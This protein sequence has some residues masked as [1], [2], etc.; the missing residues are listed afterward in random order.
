MLGIDCG[1]GPRR[2]CGLADVGSPLTEDSRRTDVEYGL[3]HPRRLAIG[4]ACSLA[5]YSFVVRRIG[6]DNLMAGGVLVWL[7]LSIAT[8]IYFA[9]AS[10][11]LIWPMLFVL[12]GWIPLL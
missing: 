3:V 9:G 1:G 10:Y 2:S 11:L 8:T 4:L 7:G 12:L 6:S 5:M